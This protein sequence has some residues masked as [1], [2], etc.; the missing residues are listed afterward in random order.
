MREKQILRSFFVLI[1][2]GKQILRPRAPRSAQDDNSLKQKR[3]LLC[4]HHFA[5]GQ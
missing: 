1:D 5:R 3:D 2:A 4:G